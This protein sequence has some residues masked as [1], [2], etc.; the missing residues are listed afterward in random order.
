[1][2][3]AKRD[4][5]KNEDRATDAHRALALRALSKTVLKDVKG[6]DGATQVYSSDPIC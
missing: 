2:K 3:N 6:G 4:S 1:M 5:R